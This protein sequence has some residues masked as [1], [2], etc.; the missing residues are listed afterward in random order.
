M[1]LRGQDPTK[2]GRDKNLDFTQIGISPKKINAR[3]DYGRYWDVKRAAKA[4]HLSQGGGTGFRPKM[5]VWVEKKF[6]AKEDY[7]RAY[8]P[9][10]DGLRE[11][12]LFSSLT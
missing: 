4:K 12:D 2:G 5:P 8:P 3:I 1:R 7:V 9:P 11:D 6:L 10:P